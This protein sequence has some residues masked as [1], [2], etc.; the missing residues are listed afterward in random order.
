MP[1]SSRLRQSDSQFARTP[2]AAARS[3]NSTMPAPNRIEKMPMN[4]WSTNTSPKTPIVQSSQ[5]SV[6]SAL[7]LK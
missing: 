7:R 2:L 6:P 4:F 1:S 5:V 3:A